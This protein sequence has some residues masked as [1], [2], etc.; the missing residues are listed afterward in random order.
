MV[1]PRNFRADSTSSSAESPSEQTLVIDANTGEI[2][3][4]LQGFAPMSYRRPAKKF[5]WSTKT[6][7]PMTSPLPKPKPQRI[8]PWRPRG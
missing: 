6:A 4:R 7:S 3:R 5:G 2:L 1:P 8:L